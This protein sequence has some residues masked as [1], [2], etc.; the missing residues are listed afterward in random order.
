VPRVD[1]SVDEQNVSRTVS[2]DGVT[3]VV[4]VS[5]VDAARD[6]V[7]AVDVLAQIRVELQRNQIAKRLILSV[8]K[9]KYS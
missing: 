8:F 9:N 3:S 2:G 5:I 7:E 1:L 4:S 6:E